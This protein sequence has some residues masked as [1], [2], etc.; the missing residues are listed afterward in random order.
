MTQDD[1]RLELTKIRYEMTMADGLAARLQIE[2]APEEM[3][4]SL[5]QRVKNAHDLTQKLLKDIKA[6]P[7]KMVL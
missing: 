5:E 2:G 3:I 1:K 6:P 4:L 7:P